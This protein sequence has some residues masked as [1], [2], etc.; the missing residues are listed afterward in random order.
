MT[1]HL[2]D[3]FICAAQREPFKIIYGETREITLRTTTAARYIGRL[4][5]YAELEILENDKIVGYITP[6]ANNEHGA[7]KAQLFDAGLPRVFRTLDDALR[8]VL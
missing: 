3:E 4:A 2:N 6:Y 5:S 7:V 8:E 1:I